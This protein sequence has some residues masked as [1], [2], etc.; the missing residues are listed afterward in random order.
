MF[1]TTHLLSIYK[2]KSK[3]LEQLKCSFCN[4]NCTKQLTQENTIE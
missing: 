3:K 2:E 4:E 1:L